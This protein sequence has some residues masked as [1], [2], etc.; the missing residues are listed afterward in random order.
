M[1]LIVLKKS[2]SF[3]TILQFILHMFTDLHWPYSEDYT[4]S[5]CKPQVTCL[6]NTFDDIIVETA[7]PLLS[8][9]TATSAPE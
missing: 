3:F 6:F 5:V 1:F 8:S 7:G 4:S 2:C 9:S